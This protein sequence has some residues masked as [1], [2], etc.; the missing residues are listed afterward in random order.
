MYTA[1][2]M[3]TA[4][5]AMEMSLPYSASTPADDPLKVTECKLAGDAVLNLLKMDLKPRDIMTKKASEHAITLVL[6]LGGSTN[7]VLHL[8]AMA[9]AVNIDVSLYV[10]EDLQRYGGVRS[11]SYEISSR[12]WQDSWRLRDHD[13]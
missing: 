1:N 11:I 6:V 7:A 13:G 5:E 10:M 4:V 9:R 3:A 12:Y 2:T 8:I